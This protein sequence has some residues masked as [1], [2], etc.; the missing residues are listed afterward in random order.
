MD[1]PCSALDP[2]STAKI[3]ELI[4]ELAKD[5]TLVVVTHNLS[6]AERISD[7]TAFF[8]FGEIVESGPS[9]MVFANPREASTRDYV[10]GRFG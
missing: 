9:A 5:H 1:E 3:E 8:M 10:M 6:Q 4:A 2:I 7:T